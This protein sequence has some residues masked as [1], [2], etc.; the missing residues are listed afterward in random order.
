MAA[1]TLRLIGA[2]YLFRLLNALLCRTYFQPDEY[3]QSLEIAHR[4]V[5]GYGYQSWEW[6]PLPDGSTGGIRSPLHPFLFVPLYWLLR[7]LRLDH[8]RLIIILP[9]VLQA[10]IATVT[11]LATYSLASVLLTPSYAAAA[12]ACS[13]TSL[14]NAYAGIRTF[15]NSLETALT[16]SALAYWPWNPAEISSSWANLSFSIL[17]IALSVIIR[18]SSILFWSLLGYT[19]LQKSNGET[20]MDVMAIV[21]VMGV[22]S[23]LACFLIDSSF[24]GVAT[25][26]PL[27]FVRQN[28][29][30]DISSFYGVNRLHFYFTQAFTFVNFSM[31]PTVILGMIM[32][33][34]PQNDHE[35]RG[36]LD[37]LRSAR[38]AVLGTMLGL[39]VLRHKEF[40]FIEPLL[41]LF[42]CFAARAMV[43]NY[44][45][46]RLARPAASPADVSP[47]ERIL[48]ARPLGFILRS[49]IS[50]LAAVYLLGF[51]YRA[52]VSVI[53]YLREVPD[54]Q[55]KSV[56][57]LTPCHSTPWQSHLHKPHL[58]PNGT[59][60]R[61][62]MLNCEPPLVSFQ[63]SSL[64]EADS[65]ANTT[66]HQNATESDEDSERKR[67]T[68]ATTKQM[69]ETREYEDE[70]SEFYR[71]PTGFL[72][73]RFP[74]TVDRG[75]PATDKSLQSYQWPSHLVLFEALWN[76]TS[77]RELLQTLGYQVVWNQTNGWW[78][79]DPQR[80]AGSVIV[81][82]SL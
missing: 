54:L 8:T 68:I 3:Y 24:Y 57:F 12:L 70:A 65:P 50:L 10:G 49:L 75:Y 9:K 31:F 6:R 29:L 62:W 56:G 22:I 81:L 27:N 53:D 18:P 73:A 77:V 15:S 46:D 25:F 58:A 16:A 1:I 82:R 32:L 55:L 47:L 20:R 7:I 60:E 40:R 80:R 69:N 34:T 26:T 64:S 78:H 33:A 67:E 39:S 71:D 76:H 21:A 36:Q 44:I 2:I 79:D 43:N 41:P 48:S 23:A 19:L 38:V 30:N 17:L 42:N 14:F 72:R 51:H 61:L 74:G 66:T 35:S 52:Q 28:L 45:K 11:D 5:F 63:N 37:R 4:L 13:L 59:Q